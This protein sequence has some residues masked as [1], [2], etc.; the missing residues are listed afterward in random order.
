ML[1]AMGPPLA[2][3]IRVMT[4]SRDRPCKEHSSHRDGFGRMLPQIPV[5]GEARMA[6]HEPERQGS[7]GYIPL[8]ASLAMAMAVFPVQAGLLDS[9]KDLLKPESTAGNEQAES[10]LGESEIS[11]ALRDALSV[12]IDTVVN[13]LGVTDGFNLDPAVHIALPGSLDKARSTLGKIGMA[14]TFDELELSLNRAAEVAVPKS[15]QLLLDA[16]QAMTLE[17]V[18]AIYQGPEDAATQYFRRHMEEPLGEAMRPVVVESLNE[19][20]AARLYG[21]VADTYNELPFVTPIDSDLTGHV[22]K[23]GTDG[24]FHYLGQEEA[25]IRS[26]PVKRTTELLKRAFG[27]SE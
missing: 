14:D 3:G 18:M 17:D 20:G 6:Q 16:V 27:G 9:L 25:A 1:A 11:D 2:H 21:Q 24:I 22:L 26:D 10:I 5:A 12:G 19:V 8:I 13:Q 15:R 4:A 7:R 23:A